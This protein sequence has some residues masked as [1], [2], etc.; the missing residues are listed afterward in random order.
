MCHRMR[1]ETCFHY[2]LEMKLSDG[3]YASP[4]LSHF[5]WGWVVIYQGLKVVLDQIG[6][7]PFPRAT[8][9]ARSDHQGNL[10]DRGQLPEIKGALVATHFHFSGYRDYMQRLLSGR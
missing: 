5:Q 10:L 3:S 7:S 2:N 6:L 1:S 8:L 4:S 9:Q